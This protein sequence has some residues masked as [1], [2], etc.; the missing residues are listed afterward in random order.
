MFPVEQIA[1]QPSRLGVG[2]QMAAAPKE[3]L[4]NDMF[5]LLKNWHLCCLLC[6]ALMEPNETEVLAEQGN[7]RV[8][9]CILVRLASQVGPIVLYVSRF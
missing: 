7:W 9:D 6:E 1:N 3:T 5:N 4:Q 8:E 2:M